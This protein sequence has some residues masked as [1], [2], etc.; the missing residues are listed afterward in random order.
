M[1]ACAGRLMDLHKLQLIIARPCF[2]RPLAAWDQ[3]ALHVD[4]ISHVG[5]TAVVSLRLISMRSYLH[6]SGIHEC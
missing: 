6:P 4:E 1:Q 2:M 5:V 3:A